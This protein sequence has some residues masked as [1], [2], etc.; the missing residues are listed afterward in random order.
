MTIPRLTYIPQRHMPH[1]LPT[2]S[3][4]PRTFSAK[5]M[6]KNDILNYLKIIKRAFND[7]WVNDD[8][9]VSYY[10][11]VSSQT[12]HCGESVALDGSVTR[13]TY[14]AENTPH[15]PSQTAY[16]LAVDFDLSPKTSL[17]IQENISKT[18]Y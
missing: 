16:A 2:Y 14:Y 6:M 15:C 4:E 12:A 10:G 9:S 8:G 13:Y 18:Q 1:I 11:E 3:A 7:A 5:P 17:K